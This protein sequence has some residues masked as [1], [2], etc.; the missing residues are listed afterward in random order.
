M[1]FVSETDKPKSLE[2]ESKTVQKWRK[3]EL[4]EL[5]KQKEME[6]A[7]ERLMV[8]LSMLTPDNAASD[9]DSS[10]EGVERE[11]KKARSQQQELDKHEQDHFNSQPHTSFSGQYGP[12]QT[13]S[14]ALHAL[15]VDLH[16]KLAKIVQKYLLRSEH[17]FKK[18][19]ARHNA[20]TDVGKDKQMTDMAIR[21]FDWN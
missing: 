20:K 8:E 3:A 10:E 7:K 12:G 15:S 9:S 19:E 17:E 13:T 11:M 21:K 16:S 2:L 5:N 18:A 1:I 6:G 14:R 4:I